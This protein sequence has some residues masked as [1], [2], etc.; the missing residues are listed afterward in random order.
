M[1]KINLIIQYGLGLMLLAFLL[2]S[3]FSQPLLAQ[4]TVVVNGH[5]TTYVSFRSATKAEHGTFQ[6]ERDQNGKPVM[7]GGSRDNRNKGKEKML[8]W[9]ET[10]ADLNGGV[11]MKFV[12]VM[13]PGSDRATIRKAI[14]ACIAVI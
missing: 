12:E 10:S 8:R 11:H 13:A 3:S 9:V 14:F 5:N 1:K 2:S 7:I 6:I 4:P